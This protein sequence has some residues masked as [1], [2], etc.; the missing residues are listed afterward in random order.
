MNTKR[1]KAILLITMSGLFQSIAIICIKLL[2]IEEV[3]SIE[4]CF[5]RFLVLFLYTNVLLKIYNENPV[6]QLINA[7]SFVRK[8][9]ISK[10]FI[11]P[12]V[13]TLYV[14]V[15]MLVPISLG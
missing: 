10:M 15:F 5:A 11:A 4:M 6:E 8:M 1:L 3:T 14:L 9:I 7:T 13:Q 2:N 12:F